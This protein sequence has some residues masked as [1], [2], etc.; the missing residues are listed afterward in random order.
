MTR[1]PNFAAKATG[2]LSPGNH[3]HLR[4]RRILRCLTVLGLEA[5]AKAFL[6]C[7]AEFYEDE[8]NKLLPAIS[9]ETMLYWREAVG[10]AGRSEQEK[11]IAP[12]ALSARL[13]LISRKALRRGLCVTIVRVTQCGRPRRSDSDICARLCDVTFQ[14]TLKVRSRHRIPHSRERSSP[15]A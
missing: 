6:E 15:S 12:R 10:S 14:V 11:M 8:Q 4:I 9:D 2:W 3:N 1:A 13:T 5:E 7:L